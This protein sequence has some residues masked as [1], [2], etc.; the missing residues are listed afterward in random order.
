MVTVFF[1]WWSCFSSSCWFGYLCFVSGCD[2]V[3]LVV[4]GLT[5]YLCFGFEWYVL[6]ES[7]G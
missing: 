3:F 2:C 1:W 6:Q 7:Q 4:V 5:D